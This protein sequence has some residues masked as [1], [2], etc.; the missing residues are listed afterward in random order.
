[1]RIACW[2]PLWLFLAATAWAEVPERLVDEVIAVV[3]TGAI[4][5]ADVVVETRLLLV[6]KGQNGLGRLPSALLNS[7]LEAQV[8]KEVLYQE[9]RRMGQ[10]DEE[11]PGF[12]VDRAL[13]D[14]MRRFPSAAAFRDFLVRIGSDEASVAARLKRQA[15]IDRFIEER[16]NL[17]VVVSE[18]DINEEMAHLKMEAI[19]DGERRERREWLR[20]DLTARRREAALR[21]WLAVLAARTG[22]HVLSRFSADEPA[23]LAPEEAM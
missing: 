5:R 10:S 23:R 6:E 15:K 12:D 9:M 18:E 19:D 2:L 7:V 8:S 16:L 22:V 13:R 21:D 20:R 11:P 1:M 14:L 3:G 4:T 17:Y